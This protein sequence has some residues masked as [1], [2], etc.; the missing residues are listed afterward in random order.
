MTSLLSRS[1]CIT[2]SC[3]TLTYLLPP[4]ALQHCPPPNTLRNSLSFLAKSPSTTTF[5]SYGVSLG[6][7]TFETLPNCY[8]AALS[9]PIYLDRLLRA[10]CGEFPSVFRAVPLAEL[11]LFAFWV[12]CWWACFVFGFVVP[13]LLLRCVLKFTKTTTVD[14]WTAFEQQFEDP[15]F[16]GLLLQKLWTEEVWMEPKFRVL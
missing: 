2:S 9:S 13:G 15:S 4:F 11:L 16:A 14:C 8:T 3:T 1:F 7:S 10:R 6:N 5:S 12:R